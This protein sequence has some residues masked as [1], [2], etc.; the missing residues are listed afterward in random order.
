MEPLKVCPCPVDSR[1]KAHPSLTRAEAGQ[2]LIITT[3]ELLDNPEAQPFLE[4]LLVGADHRAGM[5]GNRTASTISFPPGAARVG[6][7]MPVSGLYIPTMIAYSLLP[8]ASGN[9]ML[10]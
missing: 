5:L 4:S 8:S 10:C 6:T 1:F 2:P 7:R 3:I 9:R